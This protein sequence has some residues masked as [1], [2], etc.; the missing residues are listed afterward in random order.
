MWASLVVQRVKTA[1]NAGTWASIPGLGR[2]PG[3]RNTNLA[4]YS[5]LENPMDTGT[6][7]ASLHGVSKSQTRLSTHTQ[8]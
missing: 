7:Q 1:C 6:W 4:Q 3:E 8:E 2:Y 5:C